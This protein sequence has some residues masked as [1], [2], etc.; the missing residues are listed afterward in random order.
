MK[1]RFPTARSEVHAAVLMF[2][3]VTWEYFSL[4]FETFLPSETLVTFTNRRGVRCQKTCRFPLK[5]WEFSR[6]P[7]T[8]CH[9]ISIWWNVIKYFTN[10]HFFLGRCWPYLEISTI[11]AKVYTNGSPREGGNIFTLSVMQVAGAEY[12]R[13]FYIP[14]IER[15]WIHIKML[16]VLPWK[17]VHPETRNEVMHLSNKQL[18]FCVNFNLAILRL[19]NGMSRQRVTA[20]WLLVFSI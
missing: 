16:T 4:K 2:W 5:L 11:R 7:Y 1:P 13:R 3:C 17:S 14:S 10:K 9:F 6:T 8:F 20:R 19:F 18:L 15:V 12:C